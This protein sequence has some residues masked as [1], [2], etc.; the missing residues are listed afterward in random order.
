MFSADDWQSERPSSVYF[1]GD[2]MNV[3]AS[4]LQAHHGALRVFVD[5][6]VATAGP[7]IDAL[8]RFSFIENYGSV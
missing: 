6:C 2:V 8:P 1:L 3:E 7:D 4:V 5:S